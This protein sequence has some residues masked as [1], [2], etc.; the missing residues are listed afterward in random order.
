VVAKYRTD[1]PKPGLL[2][3]TLVKTGHAILQLG[4][5]QLVVR[6]FPGLGGLL[7][8]AVSLTYERVR[9]NTDL[10]AMVDDATEKLKDIQHER[11]QKK[12]L[13]K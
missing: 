11:A 12:I 2:R 1:G 5:I 10:P 4:I 3:D 8:P 9:K 6:Y 13:E 7:G